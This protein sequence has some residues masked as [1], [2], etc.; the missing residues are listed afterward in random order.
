MTTSLCAFL[1]GL[2]KTVI[3]DDIGQLRRRFYVP[4]SRE[5]RPKPRLEARRPSG[6]RHADR[7]CLKQHRGLGSGGSR[8]CSRLPRLRS[9][10]PTMKAERSRRSSYLATKS[11]LYVEEGWPAA[12]FGGKARIIE[13]KSPW[14]RSRKARSRLRRPS[15]KAARSPPGM[16]LVKLAR[17]KLLK[18]K[19][20]FG[21][22][23]ARASTRRP[24]RAGPVHRR[25]QRRFGELVGRW[26]EP[27]C[28]G[29]HSKKSGGEVRAGRPGA[30]ERRRHPSVG[31]R[32]P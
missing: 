31:R 13:A 14:R 28:S 10:R 18:A 30:L 25:G 32:R 9:M 20:D 1:I 4:V 5:A 26:Y 19:A 3:G 17:K 11:D 8:R 22:L 6:D 27:A 21:D 16:P 15:V 2:L 29:D 12:S 24:R 7:A 23:K